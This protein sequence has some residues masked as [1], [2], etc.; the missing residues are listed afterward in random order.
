MDQRSEQLPQ[1]E[2]KLKFSGKTV[3]SLKHP[4][5][6]EDAIGFPYGE[7]EKGLNWAAVLDGVGGLE[8]G[9]LASRIAIEVISTNLSNLDPALKSEEVEKKIKETLQQASRVVS[10]KVPG[11]ATTCVI[12]K[13]VEDDNGKTAVIGSVGD[14]RAYLLREGNLRL[15][16]EDDSLI[17]VVL[18]EEFDDTDGSDLDKYDYAIFRQRNIVTQSLGSDQEIG[19]HLYREKLNRGDMIILTSDGVHDNLT[20]RE[21]EEVV[22]EGGDVAEALVEKAKNRSVIP[23][24]ENI[25]AKPDDISAVVVEVF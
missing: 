11:G 2:L 19:V 7:E 6:N 3:A 13:I 12:V 15:I 10:E 4:D 24:E 21:I 18:R 14:S 20:T 8:H 23:K 1:K 5:R 16:T 22:A 9:E 17:P 25:R